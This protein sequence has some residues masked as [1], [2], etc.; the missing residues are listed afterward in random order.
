MLV[1]LLVAVDPDAGFADMSRE[2]HVEEPTVF[3]RDVI[4]RAVSPRTWQF[5]RGRGSASCLAV[6]RKS[7]GSLGGVMNLRNSVLM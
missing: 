5:R 7:P 6:Q 1:C 2:L 4:A 3:R